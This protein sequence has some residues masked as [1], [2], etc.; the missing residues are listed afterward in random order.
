VLRDL[1]DKLFEFFNALDGFIFLFF[2][3]VAF[4]AKS[5]DS[6]VSFVLKK[7]YFFLSFLVYSNFHAGDFIL[8]IVELVIQFL[9]LTHF[10]LNRF[11]QLLLSNNFII[12]VVLAA[13]ILRVVESSYFSTFILISSLFI[14]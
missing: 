13:A 11:P 7:G 8:K 10:I 9:V 3:T 2:G 12:R 6:F 5:F 14:W 1:G 4:F